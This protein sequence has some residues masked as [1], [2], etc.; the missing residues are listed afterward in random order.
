MVGSATEAL[1]TLDR[2][3]TGGICMDESKTQATNVHTYP[4]IRITMLPVD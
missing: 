4:T 1:K 2:S 3:P